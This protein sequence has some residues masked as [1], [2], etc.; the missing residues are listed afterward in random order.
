MKTKLLSLVAIFMIAIFS[1]NVMAQTTASAT[2]DALATIISPIA[3]TQGVDLSFGDIIKG[4]GT[5]TVA[6]N[7]DRTIDAAMESGTQLGTISAATFIVTGEEGYTFDIT[8]PDDITVAL[9]LALADDMA[10]TGFVSS[11]S[12]NSTLAAGD[13]TILVGATLNVAATQNAGDYTGTFDITV[14]YN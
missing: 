11:P 9:S 14:A 12:G 10:V 5:V 6:T 7:G 8:L 4:A 2:N 3:I 1:N 13:N